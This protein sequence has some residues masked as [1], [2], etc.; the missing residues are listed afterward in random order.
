MLDR[1]RVALCV[2]MFAVLAFNPMGLFINLSA[3]NGDNDEGIAA[4]NPEAADF[5][6]PHTG[7]RMIM[8]WFTGADDNAPSAGG[9][10]AAAGS[11]A[12]A[13]D[14]WMRGFRWANETFWLWIFNTVI[15]VLC[16]TKLLIY[17][18]PITNA[19]S[20]SKVHYWRHRFVW[21]ARENETPSNPLENVIGTMT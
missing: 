9:G 1:S 15:V 8:S 19:K 21:A 10:A 11:T 3:A 6:R 4:A 13:A 2:F 20:E 14:G 18:E 17:G 16:L 5:S 12:E 7:G